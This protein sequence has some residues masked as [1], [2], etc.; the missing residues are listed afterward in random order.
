MLCVCFVA[1]YTPLELYML[2]SAGIDIITSSRHFGPNY[3]Q[4]RGESRLCAGSLRV[5][6][7]CILFL[8]AP[9]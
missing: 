7:G 5:N 6:M 3:V 8:G 2:R 1:F 4:D 9:D